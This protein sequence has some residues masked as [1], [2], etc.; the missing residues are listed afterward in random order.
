MPEPL[1]ALESVTY[2]YPGAEAPA[3]DAVSVDVDEAEL[4]LVAGV[5]GSGKSTLLRAASGLVPHFFGGRLAGSVTVGGLDTRAHG[6][7]EVAG[8]ASTLFQDPES[9]VVMSSV[10]A[11]IAL[12]LETRGAVGSGADPCGRGDRARAGGGGPARARNAHALRGRASAGRARGRARH[13]A[14]AAAAGRADVSAR[15]GRGRRARRTATAAERGVGDE[16]AARRAAHRALPRGRRSRACVRARPDRVGRAAARVRRVGRAARARAGAAGGAHV[17]A[18][19]PA[20]SACRCQG[21]TGRARAAI[22]SPRR[23]HGPRRNRQSVPVVQPD[24]RAAPRQAGAALRAERLW[25][26][27]DDGSPGRHRGPARRGPGASSPARRSRSSGATARG[28]ARCCARRRAWSGPRGGG[29]RRPGRSRCCCRA[30]PTIWCTSGWHDE[31]PP[32]T[33]ARRW[34]ELGSCTWPRRDPRDLSGG[35]RQRLALGIVLAGTRHRRRRAARG[36]GAGRADARSRP[37]RRRPRWRSGCARSRREA[38]PSLTA[39]H[40]VEFAATL[41]VA[42]RTARARKRD[43]G[44]P[45]AQRCCPAGGT[46][47]PRSRAC[48]GRRP[49]VVLPEDGAAWLALA[50][51]RGGGP[52]VTWQLGSTLLVTLALAAGH[53]LVR[54]QPAAVAAGRAGRGAR[55]ARG[56]GPRAV[57]ADPERAGDDRRRAA[58]R[59]CARPA[60]GIRGRRRRRAGVELLPR[61]RAPGRPGRCSAGGWRASGGRARGGFGRR[62]GRWPLALACAAAGFAFG[63]WM[64]LFTVM[65]FAAERSTAG[66]PDGRRRLVAVQRRARDRQRGAVPRA[67]ARRSC[68]CSS[69]SAAGCR[70]SGSSLERLGEREPRRAR[71]RRARAGCGDGRTR[72]RGR[73]SLR[74]LERAQNADG[75]FGGAPRSALEPA[76]HGLGGD[77]ARGGGPQSARRTPRPAGRR[78]TTSARISGS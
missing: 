15:S 6:P 74:Y 16:R 24:L 43:G 5:S 61:A 57:H 77:R 50:Y 1:L 70:S 49:D 17:L 38:R 14:T 36:D 32:H 53:R 22:G 27:F 44:R 11:E 10:G 55:R 7:A 8:V 28:R 42:L 25:V 21:R 3:L 78:S 19:R 73:S 34:T 64:D 54:A 68:A 9:Q 46:S 62:L 39:T 65:T 67:R 4:V 40:D 31:L 12:P 63:A 30:P 66:L 51:S 48:C 72:A 41:A 58:L 2:R 59:V 33:R 18:R 29:S 71:A 45:D 13:P 47:R 60:A 76:A 69:A 75:G 23:R 52:G 20:P 26:E 37:R 56:C 35:E